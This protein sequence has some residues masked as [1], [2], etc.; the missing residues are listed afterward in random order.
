MK[1][2]RWGCW[3]DHLHIDVIS[4]NSIFFT[5]S[6]LNIS[7]SMIFNEMLH[8]LPVKI[9]LNDNYYVPVQHHPFHEG[10]TSQYLIELEILLDEKKKK[11][12]IFKIGFLYSFQYQ[13]T[14]TTTDIRINDNLCTVKKIT[15]LSFP[16]H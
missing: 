12:P 13:P 14:F 10:V 5:I 6:C 7:P 9:V 11:H 1:I 8:H 2:L 15:E 4:I 16:D 3:I